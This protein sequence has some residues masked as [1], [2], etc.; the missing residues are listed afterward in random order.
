MK[1]QN[2]RSL[3]TFLLGL[4]FIC[5]AGQ[6]QEAL[7]QQDASTKAPAATARDKKRTAQSPEEQVVRAAYEKLTKLNR[8]SLLVNGGDENT[9]LPEDQYLKFELSNFRIGPVDEIL[10]AV[11]NKIQTPASGEIIHLGRTSRSHNQGE[12]FVGYRAKWEAG[13][14]STGYDHQWTVNDIFNLEAAR[15]YD[16]GGI[17]A[18]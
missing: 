8:A 11:V 2:R 16:V 3:T 17:C 4:A 13:Q 18:I 6:Q 15:Y 5:L 7:S 14:Y 1:K 12:R 9:T 10:N